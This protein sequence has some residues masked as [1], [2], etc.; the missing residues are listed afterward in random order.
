MASGAA[1]G[2]VWMI[3]VHCCRKFPVFHMQTHRCQWIGEW[4]TLKGVFSADPDAPVKRSSV[5]RLLLM[6]SHGCY[7]GWSD[8][9]GFNTSLQEE[10]RHNSNV[11]T[12]L[13]GFATADSLQR[14]R[15]HWL[16]SVAEWSLRKSLSRGL[17]LARWSCGGHVPCTNLGTFRCCLYL[18][19]WQ[20]Y[21]CANASFWNNHCM[22]FSVIMNPEMCF[23]SWSRYDYNC[24]S[25]TR[26]GSFLYFFFCYVCQ[27]LCMH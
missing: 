5:F 12:R 2:R 11:Q 22:Y 13:I 10:V 18:S 7:T 16:R 15:Y 23:F 17:T 24:C 21:P 3:H 9:N 25:L 4:K 14:V 20:C 27:C 6:M 26:V 19:L 1:L 8:G